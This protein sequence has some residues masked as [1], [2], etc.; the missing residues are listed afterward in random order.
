[1]QNIRNGI[2]GT[3]MPPFSRLRS[4][5]TWQLISYIRSLSG[6]RVPTNER[7][8]GSVAAG[9]NIFYGK[10]ACN[11]CHEVNGRGGI[12]GPD[13]SAA[14]RNPAEMLRRKILEPNTSPNG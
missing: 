3:A 12:V 7:V 4:N 9:E 8:S 5:Q 10:G 6:G 11:T 1:F 2:G 14:G 13:L